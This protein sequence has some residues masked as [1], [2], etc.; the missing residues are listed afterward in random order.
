MLFGLTAAVLALLGL[1]GAVL[2]EDDGLVLVCLGLAVV[3]LIAGKMDRR[4]R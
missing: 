2:G 3:M 1:A 4:Q